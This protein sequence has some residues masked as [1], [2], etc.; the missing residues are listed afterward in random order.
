MKIPVQNCSSCGACANVCTRDAISMQLNGEGFYQPV[1]DP[2]KCIL[3]GACERACPW[4]NAVENPNGSAVSPKTLAAYSKDESVRS[5]SS[6]GGIF[7]VLAERILDDGGVVVGVSQLT[8]TKIGHIVIDNKV[9]LEKLRGSK[10]VQADVG[11]VYREVRSL[12]KSGK[13]VLFSGTPCQVAALYSVLGKAART[14]NLF[15]VDIVCFGVPSVKVFQKYVKELEEARGSPLRQFVFRDKSTGWSTYSQSYLFDDE[16]T[17]SEPIGRSKYMQL[18]LNRICLNQSCDE[19]RY[20]RLP[21]IADITLGDFWRVSNYHPEMDD[22]RGTSVV[23][24]NTA[25]GWELFDSVA[26]AVVQCE[27]NVENVI[28]GNPCIVKSAEP[29]PK[30]SEF[31]ANL[32][33]NSLDELMKKFCPFPSLLKKVYLS[34]RGGLGRLKLQ[35]IKLFF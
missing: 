10:Y 35:V 28:A 16:K 29:H 3:C 8:P 11:F 22:N 25:H 27:S 24:L 30:R 6:S 15:T 17:V 1:I 32:D 19:C 2:D 20:R 4:A 12:L 26:G 7:T 9:D 31:F 33:K 21:R 34:I 18:F 23:L 5:E 13:K 14:P